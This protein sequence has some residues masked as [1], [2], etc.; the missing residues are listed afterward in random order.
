MLICIQQRRLVTPSRV[1]S[2]KRINTLASSPLSSA[3]SLL[4][5]QHLPRPLIIHNPLIFSRLPLSELGRID[6]LWAA[7]G[8]QHL[9]AVSSSSVHQVLYKC[10][11]WW[12]I[13]RFFIYFLFIKT[14]VGYI[15]FV[16]RRGSCIQVRSRR[17]PSIRF[18]TGVQTGGLSTVFFY[19][20]FIQTWVG[21]ICFVPRREP[22]I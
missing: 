3:L 22:G 6:M 10:T 19:F 4:S 5:A 9:S 7:A 16:P 14:W 8:I 20:L 1:A 11:D 21:Y 2:S 17:C 18:C 15:C 12:T 13:H